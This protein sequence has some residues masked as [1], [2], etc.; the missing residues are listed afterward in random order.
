ML[1]LTGYTV[2]TW[3]RYLG[4]GPGDSLYRA[5]CTNRSKKQRKPFAARIV[6]FSA[7]GMGRIAIW[8]A[9]YL[10]N[11]PALKVSKSSHQPPTAQSPPVANT[12]FIHPCAHC[13]LLLYLTPGCLKEL[14]QMTNTSSHTQ[15]VAQPN[16][17]SDSVSQP[18]AG[19]ATAPSSSLMGSLT[20]LTNVS[21]GNVVMPP[22]PFHPAP[23]TGSLLG[24]QQV[25]PAPGDGE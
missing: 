12:A 10:H 3:S 14:G 7:F 24:M 23:L 1:S 11:M 15:H 20:G 5:A 6:K 22:P 13:L 2:K 17:H 18:T 25:L 16:S 4:S 8:L 9:Y 21:L 19:P